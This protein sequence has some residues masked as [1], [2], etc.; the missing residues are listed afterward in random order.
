VEWGSILLTV[1]SRSAD[2]PGSPR[3]ADY[4]ARLPA[5]AASHP[6]CLAKA[7]MLRR[8]LAERP[9]ARTHLDALPPAVRTLV[10]CPPLDGE[11]VPDVHL[12]CALF[13][14][15]DAYR[16]TDDD[17]LGWIH[18]LNDRMFRTLFSNLM[19]VESPEEILRRVPERWSVFHRGSTLAVTELEPGRAVVLMRFPPWLF[20]GLSLRQFVPVWEAALQLSDP[21]ARV[22]P[23]SSDEVSARF[24]A[25]WGAP[26]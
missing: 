8:S 6:G 19:S 26:P 13:T 3:V 17:Y 22:E 14:I 5:G 20:H 12:V 21:A 9:L 10:A 4:L 24:A 11:W 15:A 23:I 25:T 18:A 7:A 1:T 2:S 16:M